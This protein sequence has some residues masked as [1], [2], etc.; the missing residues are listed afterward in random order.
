MIGE[1]DRRVLISDEVSQ[2]ALDRFGAEKGLVVDYRPGLPAGRLEAIIGDYSALVVRSQTKVTS[3]VIDAAGRLQVIGRAGTGVDNVDLDAATRRGIVVMNVPGG[4]TVSAAEH[5]MG[6]LLAMARGIPAA[7]RSMRA[8]AWERGR[9]V[10]SE[11]E[12]KTLGVVG[13]GKVGREVAHRARAFE[14]R[15]IAFDPFVSAEEVQ[16]SKIDVVPLEEIFT[17]SDFITIHTPLT[18]QTRHLVGETQLAACRPGVRIVNCAR[19]GILDEAALAR[20]LASGHV[21][22]AAIDV[23]EQ[24]PPPKDHPFRGLD[25]VVL[26][27]HLA[28][29]TAEAQEK[30]AVSIAEQVCDYLRD[31]V[32]R[33]AV[34]VTPMDPKLRERL[35]PYLTLAEKLGRFQAQ[36]LEGRLG[37]VTVEYSGEIPSEALPALTV[38]VLKGYFERFLSGPVNAVNAA[39]IARERGIRLDETRT[40]EPQDY[41]NL[42]TTICESDRGRQEVAGTVFGRNLPRIVRLDGFRFDAMPEG[43]LLLV[44]NDDRPGIVGMVGSLLGE[45]Q[46]NIAYM[47]LGRDRVG[48]HAIAVINIDSRLPEALANELRGRP[49]ILWVKTVAL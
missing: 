3:R 8:G 18:P 21:A 12:G 42:I 10:G 9:F 46:V 29:S 48:G 35:A 16:R 6:M 19:G 39:Y 17:R 32:A 13:L 49:G 5:T 24:E 28:A 30:V 36:T 34:N 37:R 22:G 44:S 25:N 4:N 23:Y 26:T 38:A 20:H 45:G 31:G 43:E 2:S 7:D 14:M 40:S 11:L 41:I 27:P 15:V 33:N 47:S 1:A